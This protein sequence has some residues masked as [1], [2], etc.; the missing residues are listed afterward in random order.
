MAAKR[1]PKYTAAAQY[2]RFVEIAKK[3]GADESREAFDKAF[4]KVVAV[5]KDRASR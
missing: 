5:K 2:K 4:K 3:L 1:K